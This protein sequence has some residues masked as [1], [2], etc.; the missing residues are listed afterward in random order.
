M[1]LA[2]TAYCLFIDCMDGQ[3]LLMNGSTQF[4][5]RVEICYNNTYGTV[6]DDRFDKIDAGIVCRQ[7]GYSFEGLF[8]VL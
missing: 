4:E 6:C 7:L 8:L 3:V 5:G 2:C 1:L